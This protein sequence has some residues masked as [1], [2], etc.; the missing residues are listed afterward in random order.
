MVNNG[1]ESVNNNWGSENKGDRKTRIREQL[2]KHKALNG[3]ILA[4]T[5][6]L[7]GNMAVAG[8]SLAEEMRDAGV[9]EDSF[10]WQLE[11]GNYPSMVEMMYL[12]KACKVKA[13][14]TMKECYAVAEY[15][16]AASY[17]KA[18]Q[19]DGQEEKAAYYEKKME[20]CRTRMGT[21][22]F[23]ADDIER[24]LEDKEND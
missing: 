16:E 18:Y 14:E 15:F 22:T 7:L 3:I 19:R 1:W 2:G 23:A 9:G 11:S 5:L 4:L 20:D 8:F 6:L 12:N 24:V 17:Q 21:L 10:L 13:T